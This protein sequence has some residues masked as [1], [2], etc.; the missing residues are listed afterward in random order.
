MCTI[1]KKFLEFRW[2]ECR[3]KHLLLSMKCTP[4]KHKYCFKCE[5]ELTL[6]TNYNYK[7]CKSKVFT[8]FSKCCFFHT[9]DLQQLKKH[10]SDCVFIEYIQR[11][12]HNMSFSME[13][14]YIP[15]DNK[16]LHTIHKNDIDYN[17]I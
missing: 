4:K 6:S 1:C 8:C 5:K 2:S 9:D 12:R 14:S 13:Y 11:D 7:T 3:N 17:I 16:L 10:E 15:E